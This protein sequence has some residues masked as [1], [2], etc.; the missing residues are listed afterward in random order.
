M[1]ITG[2]T[3]LTMLRILLI[4]VFVV[5]AIYYA[6]SVRDGAPVEGFR[7]A[8]VAT[9]IVAAASDGIDGWIARRFNQKSRLGAILDPIADKGLVITALIT[10]SVL[11]WGD[12]N[13][14]IPVWFSALVIAR[15]IIILL[16]SAVVH[17]IN[18]EVHTEPHWTGK[19]CTFLLMVSLGWVMLKFIPLSPLYPISVTAI[20]VVLSGV[21]YVHSGL[22]Q[23]NEHEHAQ[24]Q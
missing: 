23:L 4:P 20:F 5:F 9:F 11:E 7:W 1:L 15:D 21:F 22:R 19:V 14:H 13:W 16:G 18:Q 2:A 6:A 24:S 8:A 17:L 3:Y 10:L 12:G